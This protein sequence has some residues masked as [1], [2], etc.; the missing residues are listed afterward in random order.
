MKVIVYNQDGK[1]SGE[2]QLPE[3]IFGV[4]KNTNLIHQVFTSMMSNK[5]KPIAH[6]KDRGEVSGGG[7]KPWRQKGT[8]RARHGSIRSPL[9]KGGGVTFGPS[10][11]RNFKKLVPKKIKR[12]ALL[13]ALSAKAHDGEIIVLERLEIQEPKTKLLDG[14]IGN[15]QKKVKK[16]GSNLII[17]P[18]KNKNIETASGNLKNIKTIEARNLNIIDLLSFKNIIVPE[19]SIKILKELFSRKEKKA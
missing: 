9:W 10:N 8:G 6:A 14:M 1:E 17:L 4:K 19:D 5:R 7:R 11:E 12:M 16:Q 2:M 13:S 3:E 15:I 18:Q